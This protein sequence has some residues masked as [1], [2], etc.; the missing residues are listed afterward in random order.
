MATLEG[1]QV[2][3]YNQFTGSGGAQAPLGGAQAPM[4]PEQALG[5]I[6]A[7]SPQMGQFFLE[8]Y[9][10]KVAGKKM[11][12]SLK[13]SGFD[14]STPSGVVLEGLLK[15]GTVDPE[16]ATRI[17]IQ[18]QK[19]ELNNIEMQ[20]KYADIMLKRALADLY[21]AQ[22]YQTYRTTQRGDAEAAVNLVNQLYAPRLQRIEN[23]KKEIRAILN[24]PNVLPRLNPTEIRRLE[25]RL[26]ALDITAQILTY[27]HKSAVQQVSKLVSEGVPI[28]NAITRAVGQ[29]IVDTRI[30]FRNANFK[31]V[32]ELP[33]DQDVL[34]G[35]ELA[36]EFVDVVSVYGSPEYG[37][38]MKELI[39]LNTG[40]V[41]DPN[42]DKNLAEAAQ[43]DSDFWRNTLIAGGS[44]LAGL[45][46]IKRGKL[47]KA[48][49]TASKWFRRKKKGV[50]DKKAEAI[51]Q[52]FGIPSLEETLG[53]GATIQRAE[54]INPITGRPEPVQP[55]SPQARRGIMAELY[56]RRMERRAKKEEPKAPRRRKKE[57]G[58]G[59]RKKPKV[60]TEKILNLEPPSLQGALGGS[61]S[62]SKATGKKSSRGSSSKS[63]KKKRKKEE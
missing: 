29:G 42:L 47:A 15:S 53:K 12:E 19:A 62:K 36:N 18:L 48:W 63:S 46:Y 2:G 38:F 58:L 8:S 16:K 44:I 37:A 60:E 33:S 30:A 6:M 23:E 10:V 32:M 9:K 49:K 34:Y 51:R 20:V 13:E 55:S 27:E 11:L 35:R 52:D 22:T 26:K 3:V 50:V 59:M 17:Y 5:I 25:Q 39:Q 24:N 41:M 40:G 31:G 21:R 14:L 4:S 57:L 56:K 43:D 28:G 61:A 45:A 7:E 54:R 1:N